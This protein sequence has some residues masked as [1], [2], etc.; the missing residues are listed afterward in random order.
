[1]K[2]GSLSLSCSVSPPCVRYELAEDIGSVFSRAHTVAVSKT[3][4][5][6]LRM[7]EP[8]VPCHKQSQPRRH[9]LPPKPA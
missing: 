8:E 9:N 5:M 1:V 4:R 2:P 7:K 3:F 6:I